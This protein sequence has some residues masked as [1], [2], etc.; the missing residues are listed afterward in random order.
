MINMVEFNKKRIA[1]G[2]A[3]ENKPCM[4]P[5]W[6]TLVQG[7]PLWHVCWDKCSLMRVSLSGEEFR[8]VEATESDLISSN[9]GGTVEQTQAPA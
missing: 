4:L 1:S 2:K 6:E 8:F 3:P 7:K 5:L 9:I